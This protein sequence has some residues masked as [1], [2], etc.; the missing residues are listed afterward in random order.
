MEMDYQ[1]HLHK[2]EYVMMRVNKGQRNSHSCLSWECFNMAFDENEAPA[3]NVY[4]EC[5]NLSQVCIPTAVTL[6]KTYFLRGNVNM[7]LNGEFSPVLFPHFRFSSM[8]LHH[9]DNRAHEELKK[10]QEDQ[11]D[12]M[13][14]EEDTDEEEESDED[15]EMDSA[16]DS[17]EKQMFKEEFYSAGYSNFLRGQNKD[18]DYK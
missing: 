8:L 9:F 12:D 1:K 11:E 3:I 5:N 17:R 4:K 15:E 6:N 14:E 7:Q 10:Q 16:I 13:L 18:F 2:Y